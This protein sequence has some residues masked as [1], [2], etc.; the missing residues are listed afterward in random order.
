MPFSTT[1]RR[2]AAAV[3]ALA[4][5]GAG[6]GCGGGGKPDGIKV[7]LA[8]DILGGPGDATFVKAI[9]K[10]IA[11]VRHA[12]PGSIAEVRELTS[13]NAETDDDKYD[14]L[15]ILCQ[16]GYDPVIVS[17]WG[18]VGAD[19]DD[20]P[21]AHAAK[22]C[23]STRFA[24]LDGAAVSA[25]NVADLAFA[26]QQGAFLAGVVAGTLTHTGKLGFLGGCKIPMVVA[27]EAGFRAGARAARSGVSVEATYLSDPKRR[28]SG[29]YD[30][31][32]GRKVADKLYGHGADVVYTAAGGGDAGV[33]QSATAHDTM[34]IGW[35][36]DEFKTVD[37]SLRNC[38]VTSI[39]RHP[40][41]V[42]ADFLGK[43]LAGHFTAGVARYGLGSG[44]I[45]YA[46]SGGKIDKITATLDQYR[47]KIVDGSISVPDT[48][49]Q[50]HEHG[51]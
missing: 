34:A 27:D 43:L 31:Y 13:H 3:V 21:L 42:V 48:V 10:G 40:E 51:E 29:F 50:H 11:T 26:D 4:L 45:S 7:G 37:F 17:G 41:V 33:F 35:Y 38:I 1:V 9:K 49:P 47:Q 25:P 18:Y 23:P 36:V 20:G 44:A 15:I 22:T 39:V 6:A 46:T 12:S 16:S 32:D 5:A 30:A 24:V 19:P 8:T 2:A 14:R 28:C